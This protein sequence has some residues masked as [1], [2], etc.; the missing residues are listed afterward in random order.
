VAVL[1]ACACLAGVAL[2]LAPIPAGLRSV[3]VL[4]V[5]LLAPGL[6][7]T[8]RVGLWEPLV[9]ASL[10][11]PISAALWVLVA[12]TQIY[13]HAWHPEAGLIVVLLVSAGSLMPELRRSA[14][15]EAR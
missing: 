6:C 8:R 14:A 12:Q 11:F 10:A 15:R 13:L 3:L 2:V 1:L 5:A 9:E 7:V 4:P